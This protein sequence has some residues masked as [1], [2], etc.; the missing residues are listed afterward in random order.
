MELDGFL[1]EC[2]VTAAPGTL[3]A[4]FTDRRF[5]EKLDGLRVARTPVLVRTA[6]GSTLMVLT[7]LQHWRPTGAMTAHFREV[8]VG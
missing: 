8:G 2:E 7:S 4:K 5:F 3:V 1:M 6:R